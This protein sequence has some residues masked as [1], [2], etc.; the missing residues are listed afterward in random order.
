M[1]SLQMLPKLQ[2]PLRKPLQGLILPMTLLHT[3]HKDAEILSLAESS[4]F[5]LRIEYVSKGSS[6]AGLY[7]L[8]QLARNKA[9][10]H[11]LT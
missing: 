11:M 1:M 4:A 9:I 5:S 6:V 3:L 10:N 8:T 7:S 2:G